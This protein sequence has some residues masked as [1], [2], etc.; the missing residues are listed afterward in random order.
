MR[1]SLPPRLAIAALAV[2]LTPPAGAAPPVVKKHPHKVFVDELK[3][4][5]FW[6]MDMPFWVRLAPSPEEGTP[7]FLLKR[8]TPESDVTKEQYSNEGIALEIQ[9][10]QHIRWFNVVTNKTVHLQFFTDGEPPVSKETLF[11]APT[12]AVTAASGKRTFYGK[13]LKG[14]LSSEDALAGVDTTFF[15]IDEAEYQPY[16]DELAFDKEKEIM[17]RYYAVDRIGYANAPSAVSFTVDLTPPSSTHKV[18]GNALGDV[19]SAQASFAVAST[20]ALSGLEA[21]HARF[22]G[23]GEFR[24]TGGANQTVDALQDGEHVL[25]YYA[26]DRVAN[27]EAPHEHRF[28]VDRTP[29]VVSSAI[30]GDRYVPKAGPDFVSSRSNVALQAT[31]NKIGV[32]EITYAIGAGPFLR[33]TGPLSL[34]QKPGEV[35]VFF[36]GRDKLGN[37]SEVRTQLARVDLTPPTT[38]SRFVGPSFSQRTVVWMTRETAVHLSATDDASGVERIDYQIDQGPVTRYAAGAPIQIPEEARHVLRFWSLDNVSNKEL[39]QAL[40]IITDN[41]PPEIFSTFSVASTGT[42]TGENGESLPVYPTFTTLFLGATD[43][44][45]GVKSITYSLD[46]AKEKEYQQTLVFER[47]GRFDLLVRTE[48]NTGNATTKRVKFAVKN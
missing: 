46:G 37:A 35:K 24:V 41:S 33:Y 7:S 21:I 15:S 40:V 42:Q 31:D 8:V 39:E 3:E 9:G 10:K 20:D 29:P 34:P 36:R 5:I 4:K 43:N 26:V 1:Y 45:A 14:S 13:G 25:A 17:L 28:Y 22:D 12:A 48:D 47:E 44:S 27:Q 2:A 19:L 16:K 32:E 11:G 18:V 38:A 23:R 30:G 6:P